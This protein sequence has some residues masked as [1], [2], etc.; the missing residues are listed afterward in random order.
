MDQAVILTGDLLNTAVRS[1]HFPDW[2]PRWRSSYFRCFAGWR[3]DPLRP[4]RTLTGLVRSLA[5]RRRFKRL[6]AL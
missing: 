5:T 1:T 3:T 2:P 4:Y 6:G